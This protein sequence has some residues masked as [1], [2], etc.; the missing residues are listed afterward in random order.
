MLTRDQLFDEQKQ[1]LTTIKSPNDTPELRTPPNHTPTLTS[2]P[3]PHKNKPSRQSHPC[4]QAPIHIYFT[5]YDPIYPIYS[6]TPSLP[7]PTHS[8]A[9]DS[10]EIPA[11]VSLKGPSPKMKKQLSLHLVQKAAAPSSIGQGTHEQGRP[12]LSFI[13]SVLLV[14]NASAGLSNFSTSGG[15]M[16]C[17]CV[18]LSCILCDAAALATHASL[19]LGKSQ[20]HVF[21]PFSGQRR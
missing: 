21:P 16:W 3:I 17:W 9:S 5:T 12:M 15:C 8:L 20:Q 2:L 18:A 7:T 11:V 4:F 10:G 6:P 13:Y 19:L 1:V 14:S